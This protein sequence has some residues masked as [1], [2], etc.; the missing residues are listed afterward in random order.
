[1]RTDLSQQEGRRI[2]RKRQTAWN[3]R[4]IIS[5]S[6]VVSLVSDSTDSPGFPLLTSRS[7]AVDAH[8]LTLSLSLNVVIRLCQSLFL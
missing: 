7:T 3:V 5:L 2:T 6:T 1:M 8:V 4:V